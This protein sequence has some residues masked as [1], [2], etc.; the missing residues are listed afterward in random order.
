MGLKPSYWMTVW[1]GWT[2][3]WRR[4][5]YRPNAPAM[6]CIEA[7]FGLEPKGVDAIVIFSILF[8]SLQD[9][10]Q[11][12][13]F[14]CCSW[15]HERRFIGCDR[16]ASFFVVSRRFKCNPVAIGRYSRLEMVMF[17]PPSVSPKPSWYNLPPV[18]IVFEKKCLFL[19]QWPWPWSSSL[20]IT[21]PNSI[22][23][24]GLPHCAFVG[25]IL[26]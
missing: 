4:H 10:I 23:E 2:G 20:L 5:V 6:L 13:L 8:S 26:N 18:V 25:N 3:R 15:L 17:I 24:V 14:H 11:V 12:A 16:G 1:G 7:T 19:L 21:R 22:P 9:T